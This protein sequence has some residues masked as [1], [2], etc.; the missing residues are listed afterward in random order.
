M[1]TPGLL[2]LVPMVTVL[3]RVDGIF[4]ATQIFIHNFGND[5]GK[6]SHFIHNFGNNM[7][8]NSHVIHN[9]GNVKPIYGILGDNNFPK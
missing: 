6:Y 5:M 8:K 2:V 7:G 3:E 4:I 1:D 9:F